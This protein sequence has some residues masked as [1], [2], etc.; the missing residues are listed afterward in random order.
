[1]VS[2]AQDLLHKKCQLVVINAIKSVQA[3]FVSADQ[4]AYIH[5]YSTYQDFVSAIHKGKSK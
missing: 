2:L 5:V 3:A 1:V 4:N